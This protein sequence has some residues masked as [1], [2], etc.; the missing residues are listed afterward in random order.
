[1]E[2]TSPAYQVVPRKRSAQRDFAVSFW[3]RIH[4]RGIRVPTT[5]SYTALTRFPVRSLP[6]FCDHCSCKRRTNSSPV[7]SSP[8]SC[9]SNIWLESQLSRTNFQ[10]SWLQ[11]L[12]T[13]SHISRC[14]RGNNTTVRWNPC[15]TCNDNANPNVTTNHNRNNLN[16]TPT[17]KPY[18]LT[19]PPTRMP[20]VELKARTSSW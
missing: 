5:I 20:T 14:P 3:P 10:Q 19:P 1:M 18:L 16:N 11:F 7:S 2:A 4:L 9:C 6:V 8:P 17:R 13:L 15:H 12:Y